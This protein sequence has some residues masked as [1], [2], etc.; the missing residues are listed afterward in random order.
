[1]DLILLI[2]F[3]IMIIFIY[4]LISVIKDLQIDVNNMSMSCSTDKTK[5]KKIETLDYKLKND[6]VK[7]L[8]YIKN[9]FI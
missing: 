4:Y 5:I 6:F 8:D 9:F 3:V 2:A 7:F 1:M